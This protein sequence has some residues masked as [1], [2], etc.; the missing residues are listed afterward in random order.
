MNAASEVR[1]VLAQE[2]PLQIWRNGGGVTRELLAWPDPERWR[3]RI[4]MADV[5]RDGVFSAFPGVSRCLAILDGAGIRLALPGAPAVLR[6]GAPCVEFD[7]ALAPFCELL[8]GP[9]RDLNLMTRQGQAGMLPAVVS[10][11]WMPP[12]D[13]QAGLLT[14][15]AGRWI[16]DD[17]ETR[18][19]ACALLWQERARPSRWWFEPDD[20]A[21]GSE[22]VGWWLYY[23]Q[24][25]AHA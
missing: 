16:T 25:E 15:T 21:A 22:T 8:D 23:L 19:P 7:G 1:V 3:L 2:R 4:S 18:L 9:V 17:R 14:L 24:D 10:Q 6:R 13:A 12:A 20:P 5:E 11:C